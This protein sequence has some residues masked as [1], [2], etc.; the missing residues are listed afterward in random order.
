MEIQ[1]GS[2]NGD[3]SWFTPW[4]SK[5]VHTM[6]IQAGSHHGEPSL[7]HT[8]EIQAGSHNGDPSS[9]HNEDPSRFTPWRSKLTHW[10]T[11]WRS[12]LDLRCVNHGDPSWISQRRSQLVPTTEI[13]PGSQN[14]ILHC[15]IQGGSPLCEPSLDLTM[16]TK[17]DP[18]VQ[19][20]N[21]RATRGG[22]GLW[23]AE[24]CPAI[25]SPGAWIHNGDPSWFTQRRSRP[26]PPTRGT[27]NA[28]W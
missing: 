8:T 19:G 12:K 25:G 27:Y 13:Q 9:S 28:L 10:F 20:D 24:R 23:Y 4:R 17:L 18:L 1:A 14:H 3:P 6:E 16:R 21:G 5:L 7:D 2:H 11:P 26:V 22:W 15:V